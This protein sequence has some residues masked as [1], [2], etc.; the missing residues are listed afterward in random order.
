M[1]HQLGLKT[2][3]HIDG[4]ALKSADD[5]RADDLGVWINNGVCHVHVSCVFSKGSIC[6][7]EIVKSMQFI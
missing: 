4:E 6:N 7:I 5:V 3:C 1:Q 2:I